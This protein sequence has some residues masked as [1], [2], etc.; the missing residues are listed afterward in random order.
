MVLLIH[1]S[2]SDTGELSFYGLDF[3]FKNNCELFF[4]I[5][6]IQSYME[7]YNVCNIYIGF[8]SPRI[9]QTCNIVMVCCIVFGMTKSVF[10]ANFN[11]KYAL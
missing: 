3:R 6:A 1:L 4:R 7:I 2:P 8:K 11:Q 9:K 10:T 5:G